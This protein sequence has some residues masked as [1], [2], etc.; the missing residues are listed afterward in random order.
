MRSLKLTSTA[1]R[2]ARGTGRLSALALILS[3]VVGC[4]G[5]FD[6]DNPTNLLDEDLEVPQLI[7][8][9]SNSAEGNLAGPFSQALVHGEMIG[10]HIWHPSVQDF[11][12]LIDRGYRDRDNVIIEE[13]YTTLAAARWIADDMVTRL[14]ALVENPGGHA[15]IAYSHFWGGVAR[16]TL[17]SYFEA[18]TY[19]SEAPI[20]PAQAIEH[21]VDRF[22]QAA[23]VA[24]VAGEQNLQAGAYGA[25]ARAYR[26]LYYEGV[27]YGGGGNS[28]HF[29]Q[30]ETFARQA[31]ELRP[32]FVVNIR[33]GQPGATNGMFSHLVQGPYHRMTPQYADRVDPVSGDADPR[34]SHAGTQTPGPRGEIRYV[35]D[36]FSSLS[37]PLPVSRAAEAEL[38]VAEARFLAGDLPGAVEFINRVRSRSDLPPFAGS[39]ANAVWNQLMYERDTELWLEGRRWEDHRYYEIIPVYWE[40]VNKAAGT[41][42]RWPMSVQERSN[43]PNIPR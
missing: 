25:V 26:S 29:Q 4:S 12:L 33:Y 40:D 21:A 39:D 27:I 30:A 10:D 2:S 15:G 28:A 1:S 38:I 17:A 5:L 35:Q 13:I 22:Q 31:L 16:M 42:Q 9:L 18:V 7:N 14:Q 32:D 24:G 11:G 19:D 41:A 36:K 3:A 6:V 34:I 23:Q 43:N 20:T 37:Q 8:A